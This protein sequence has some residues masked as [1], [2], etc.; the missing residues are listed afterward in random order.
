MLFFVP[1]STSMLIIWLGDPSVC[2]KSLAA[3][4]L[5][6]AWKFTNRFWCK[7][8]YMLY[9]F[10]QKLNW[11]INN[12]AL[13]EVCGEAVNDKAVYVLELLHFF[14]QQPNHVLLKLK[15]QPIRCHQ[16]KQNI[17]S[18]LTSATRVPF[19]M[20]LKIWIFLLAS[21]VPKTTSR[22]RDIEDQ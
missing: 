6:L 20:A 5:N 3:T 15:C 11:V 13:V 21:S 2:S 19:S 8:L 14:A 9:C 4:R 10:V 7:Y 22:L 16:Q 18:T 12:P 1:R 17:C